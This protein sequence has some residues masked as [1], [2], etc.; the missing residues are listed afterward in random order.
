MVHFVTVQ[1]AI[2]LKNGVRSGKIEIGV[3]P[4]QGSLRRLNG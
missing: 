1:S 3:Q 2:F 4:E